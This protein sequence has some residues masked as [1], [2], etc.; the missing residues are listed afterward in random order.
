M[1]L[2]V[3]IWNKSSVW[4]WE[5]TRPLLLTYTFFSFYYDFNSTKHA[6]LKSRFHLLFRKMPFSKS[7]LPNALKKMPSGQKPSKIIALSAKCPF[8]NA[9]LNKMPS[10]KSPLPI[11]LYPKCPLL[12]ALCQMPSAKCPLPITLCQMPSANCPLPNALL[13]ESNCQMAIGRGQ[14]ADGIWQRATGRG[15]LAEGNWKR[16]FGRGQYMNHTLWI[17]YC[18]QIWN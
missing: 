3:N 4:K 16:A 1:R 5:K 18:Q 7:P 11:A 15:Q 12:K 10:A 2:L 17:T 6:L 8:P 13:Q 9:L 14:L